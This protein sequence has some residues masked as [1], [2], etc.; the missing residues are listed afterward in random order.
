M[1][2]WR[3]WPINT[4]EWYVPYLTVQGCNKGWGGWGGSILSLIQCITRYINGGTPLDRRAHVTI[5]NCTTILHCGPH[6]MVEELA[7]PTNRC[8]TFYV[9][10]SLPS[11]LNWLIK[12][13]KCIGWHTSYVCKSTHSMGPPH[14]VGW[15]QFFRIPQRRR[16]PFVFI[17]TFSVAASNPGA[18]WN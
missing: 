16:N 10:Y 14:G 7:L 5:N 11:S 3:T 1:R 12:E 13:F 4:L 2:K 8:T 15:K 17:E 6:V 9:L 18:V